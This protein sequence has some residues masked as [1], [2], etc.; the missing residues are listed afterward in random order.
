MLGDLSIKGNN[1]KKKH[2]HKLKNRK[3]RRGKKKTKTKQQTKKAKKEKKNPVSSGPPTPPPVD[4]VH[5]T[6]EYSKGYPYFLHNHLF[7]RNKKRGY[8]FCARGLPFFISPKK[9]NFLGL[10]LCETF[11]FLVAHH[12]PHYIKATS[13]FSPPFPRVYLILMTP[14]EKKTSIF[15]FF[16][17]FL[18][19]VKRAINGT[20]EFFDN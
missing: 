9:T 4:S 20:L 7:S 11:F 6:F 14:K 13:P 3:R 12:C 10:C 5:Y 2:T 1:A 16:F 15:T 18:G 19:V 17:F 8:F